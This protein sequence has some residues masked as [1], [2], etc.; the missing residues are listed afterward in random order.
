MF[1]KAVPLRAA[2]VQLVRIPHAD[3]VR[4]DAAAQPGEV[5]S[6]AAPQV[7]RGRVAVQQDNRVA[8]SGLHVGHVAVQH[9]G[10][11]LFG[12]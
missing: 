6:D 9:A 12:R 2:V 5:R 10:V 3:E 1:H 11:F 7:G 8:F 4:H